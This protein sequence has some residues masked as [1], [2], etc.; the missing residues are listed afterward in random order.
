MEYSL[1]KSSLISDVV[2]L[3]QSVEPPV[4]LKVTLYPNPANNFIIVRLDNEQTIDKIMCYNS[5]GQLVSTC[6]VNSP[7]EYTFD[8]GKLKNGLYLLMIQ[9][10]ILC[11]V[12]KFIIE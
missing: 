4:D 2:P 12:S 3:N 8:C 9:S 5:S 7:G 6:M 1:A 10:G 11:G